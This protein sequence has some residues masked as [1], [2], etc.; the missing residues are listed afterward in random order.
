[1]MPVPQRL[2]RAWIPLLMFAIC[3]LAQ[4][5][6]TC[7][8]ELP[9]IRPHGTIA[10][11]TRDASDPPVARGAPEVKTVAAGALPGT[12]AVTSTGEAVYE[13]PLVS[14]PGRAGMEPRLALHYDSAAG[15]G[16]LGAGFSIAGLSAITRCPKNLAQD[17]EIRGVAYDGDDG[18]CLDGKRLV[19]VGRAPGTIEYRTFPDTM[20]KVVGRSASRRGGRS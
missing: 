20:V 17:G 4:P 13:L 2:K 11:Q 18:L 16:L 10:C 6:C 1:M 12:F 3:V 9:P 14:V 19:A 5:A 7:T 8:P 15:E